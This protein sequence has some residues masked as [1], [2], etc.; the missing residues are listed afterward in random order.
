MSAWYPSPPPTSAQISNIAD[1]SNLEV[2][3]DALECLTDKDLGTCRIKYLW[4]E[5]IKYTSNNF[6]SP[7]VTKEK[8]ERCRRLKIPGVEIRNLPPGHILCGQQGLF[9]T[10]KFAVFDVI[11]EYTGR[12]VD[13]DVNG[14]RT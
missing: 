12:I 6:W 7:K 9:A 1:R 14:N 13:D 5:N 4:D 11:G 2:S 8:K 10:T 3:L